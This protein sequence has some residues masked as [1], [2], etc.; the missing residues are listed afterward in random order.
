MRLVT[1]DERKCYIMKQ[2]LF[3][4]VLFFFSTM[5]SKAANEYADGYFISKNNDTLLCKI[6]IPKDFG[7]FNAI[8][9]FSKITIVDS[10]GNK[11]KY[12]ASD[13]NGYGFIYDSKTYIYVSKDVDDNGKMMF[14]W[15]VNLGKSVNEYYYYRSNS[16]DLDKSGMEM[17][18]EI[19]VLE[20]AQTGETASITRG[21]S[22]LNTYKEQ[23]RRFFEEDKRLM[24][25]ITQDVKDFND[26]PRF[27][28][29]ANK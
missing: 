28:T 8:T 18:D 9:L 10:A 15:P 24:S 1:Q 4:L 7:K 12:T 22:V 16:D 6:L 13:I 14:V 19:Y 29:D 11:K 17:P 3:F 27:I 23:L 5:D 26:I 25:L 21:G 20:N 2:V